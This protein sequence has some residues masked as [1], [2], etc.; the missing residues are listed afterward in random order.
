[1]MILVARRRVAVLV[2]AL[3]TAV[4]LQPFYPLWVAGL[5]AIALAVCAAVAGR[6]FHPA[7]APQV[8]ANPAAVL[9]AAA[10]T[11][12]IV[13]ILGVALRNNQDA[14]DY[15]F[16]AAAVV[17]FGVQLAAFWWSALGRFG[18]RL[19][20]DGI[21]DRQVY[22]RLF[23]P[24]EALATPEAAVA[25]DKHQVVLRFARPGLVRRRG[26]RLDGRAALPAAGVDADLLAR[27]I[28]EYANHAAA[29]A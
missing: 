2:I 6:V 22:S 29:R 14:V 16:A 24:W 28:N 23:V 5:P 21:T 4:A 19:T 10:C 1:M 7:P 9:R 8:P 20:P 25:R 26:L 18:V 11:F 17:I 27:T 3:L 15:W 12:F 13:P